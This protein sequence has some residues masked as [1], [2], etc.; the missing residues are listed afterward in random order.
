MKPTLKT[1]LVF[2]WL[3]LVLTFAACFHAEAREHSVI[4]G[5]TTKS[6]GRTSAILI[7]VNGNPAYR[8][9]PLGEK[10]MLIAL[11]D[12]VLSTGVCTKEAILGDEWIRGIEAEQKPLGVT[13]FLVKLHKPYSDIAYHISDKNDALQIQIKDKAPKLAKKTPIDMPKPP[14]AVPAIDRTPAPAPSEKASGQAASE[15]KAPLSKDKKW[16]DELLQIESKDSS[17]DSE[18]F[19]MAAKFYRMGRWERA[20]QH[21]NMIIDSYP[22][23]R[24]QERVYFLLAVSYHRMFE[25]QMSEHS[26]EVIKRLKEATSRF[27]RSRYV[28]H[29]LILIGRCFLEIDNYAAALAHY[30]V[31]LKNYKAHPAVA[32]ALFQRGEFFLLT[33]KLKEATGDFEEI[34]KRSTNAQ[35]VMAAKINRA[36]SLFHMKSFKRSLSVLEELMQAHPDETYKNPEI[37]LFAGYNH[38]ELG[39]MRKARDVLYR[40][41]NY[42]PEIESNHLVLTRIADSYREEGI[43]G[44]ASKLYD[45]VINKYP[46]TEGSVI[47][48]L[49]FAAEGEKAGPNN[50]PFQIQ[51]GTIATGNTAREIYEQIIDKYADNPL[52]QLAMLK[53]ALLWQKDKDYEQSLAILQ[54]ILTKHPNTPLEKEVKAALLVSLQ[55]IVEQEKQSGGTKKIVAFYERLRSSLSFEDSPD[56]LTLVGDAYKQIGLLEDAI[57]IYE[58]ARSSYA[59]EK[60]PATLLLSLGECYYHEEKFNEAER[61]LSALVTRYPKHK[62][63]SKA[64]YWMGKILLGREEYAKAVRFLDLALGQGPDQYYQ[65]KILMA[66]ADVS[67]SQGDHEKAVG[68]LTKAVTLLSQDKSTTPDVLQLA[69]EELGDTYFELEQKNKALS[70]FEKALKYGSQDSDKYSLRFRLARCYQWAEATTKAVDILNEIVASEDPLWSKVAQAEIR[71]IAIQESVE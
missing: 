39:Q 2:V 5:F 70:A 24:H 19:L 47:S 18:L 22:E 23:S 31:V 48:L 13:T 61:A 1:G 65:A 45:L 3:C 49:R 16:T 36:K 56:L 54:E 62:Q 46:D 25:K 51:D 29:A 34:E 28:P 57:S 6:E 30:N 10:E 55:A 67:K 40:L 9:I 14:V 69:Y 4:R 27:P 8:V 35:L 43:K 21:L 12:T 17:P 44:K 52:S 63:A 15:Q 42:L 38:H 68:S 58:K 20:V 11:K 26:V 7:N 53:L 37:L 66:M 64:Y 50:A 32:E 59:D 33:N 41:L 71:E 60:Q